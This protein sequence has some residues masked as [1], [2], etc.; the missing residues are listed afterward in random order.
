MVVKIIIMKS[1]FMKI[2]EDN[3]NPIRISPKPTDY[4]KWQGPPS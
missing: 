3:I 4:M 1:E 2:Y